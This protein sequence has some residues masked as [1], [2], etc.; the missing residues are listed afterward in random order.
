MT[1]TASPEQRA[2]LTR[3]ATLL[4]EFLLNARCQRR[5][6]LEPALQ[7]FPAGACSAAS[8]LLAWALRA[9]GQTAQLVTVTAFDPVTVT[10]FSHTWVCAGP[11]HVDITGDQFNPQDQDPR[12]QSARPGVYVSITPPP[13]AGQRQPRPALEDLSADAALLPEFQRFQAWAAALPALR[14]QPRRKVTA[15]WQ[16]AD[17][18]ECGH[19]RHIKSAY[20]PR[21][22]PCHF[23]PPQA[24]SRVYRATGGTD[25]L[26][27]FATLTDEARGDLIAELHARQGAASE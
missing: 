8:T 27:W 21:K 14:F 10:D 6:Q 3:T 2:A 11:Y 26:D 4:R 5:Q 18:L 13:W 19:L 23:C 15:S 20:P 17:V 16:G 1:P 12:A 9:D 25:A 7:A 22:R 24:A